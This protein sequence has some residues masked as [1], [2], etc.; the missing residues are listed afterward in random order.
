MN[1]VN[2]TKEI[3]H[4]TAEQPLRTVSAIAVIDLA[5]ELLQ[6][7]YL[8]ATQLNNLS[9][10]FQKLY[11]HWQSGQSIQ[12]ERLDES[13]MRELWQLAEQHPKKDSVGLHIG[14]KVNP[15]AKGLL[16]NWLAQCDRL[17][18]AFEVFSQH[19]HLLNPAEHWHKEI[20]HDQVK[21]SFSFQQANYPA[22][23]VDRSLAAL[24]AWGTYYSKQPLKPLK[25]HLKRSQ[26]ENI[27]PYQQHLC[28]Q[29]FFSQE[30]D[31]I[32]FRPEDLQQGIDTANPYLKS[33]IE[34]QAAKIDKHCRSRS[35]KNQVQNL[36][37]DDL[38]MFAHIEIVCRELQLSRSSLYRKLKRED[39]SF[40]S[41]LKQERIRR[42]HEFLKRPTSAA[43]IAEQLGFEDIAS[44][45][46]F[47]RQQ[48]PATT[49]ATA[50]STAKPTL[51]SNRT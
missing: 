12:E 47:R 4:S 27:E 19:I 30:E 46:R 7:G 38:A 33:L 5:Q 25:V 20:S 10:E 29:L 24:L 28:S 45:Y 11:Q 15:E 44:F 13:L 6:R 48:M 36:L 35:W 43:E 49:N 41:L 37:S 26:P 8:Q 39:C 9:Q 21:L 3:R 31:A 23:A 18:D 32:Y 17:D 40:S 22:I 51:K 1:N 14:A 42:L 16:A 2:E 50:K 34:E